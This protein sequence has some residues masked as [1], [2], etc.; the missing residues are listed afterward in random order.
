MSQLVNA[1][2]VFGL[3]AFSGF[4]DARGFVYAS[5]AW[6]DGRLDLKWGL[7]AVAAFIGGL[8]CY[9]IAVRFMQG[10]GIHSVALQSALWFVITGIGIAAMD[11]TILGWTRTQQLVG[12]AV[13]L[14]LGWLI[15]STAAAEGG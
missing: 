7:A 10:F 9:V 3:T 2:L 6:P 5:R 13:A 12:L 15:A 4:L 11:G 1:L 8:S 14:G